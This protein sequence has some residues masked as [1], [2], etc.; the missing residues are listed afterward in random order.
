MDKFE[1][2][3]ELLKKKHTIIDT[4]V[5]KDKHTE[6]LNNLELGLFNDR[7]FS[8]VFLEKDVYRPPHIH[9]TSRAEFY[10][11]EGNGLV[12]LDGKEI[13]FE[14]GT[15]LEVPAGSAHGFRI[16]EDTL[17]LSIQDGGGILKQDKTIDFRY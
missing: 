11:L 12:L 16:F 13:P 15:Y 3:A 14:K 9:D 8:I 17:F 6:V 10:F 1:K 7:A 4:G 5:L 2:I